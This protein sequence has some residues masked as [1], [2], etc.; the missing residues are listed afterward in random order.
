MGFILTK[1]RPPV[2]LFSEAFS[3]EMVAKIPYQVNLRRTIDEIET[4]FRS[5]HSPQNGRAPKWVRGYGYV[6]MTQKSA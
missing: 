6:E 2:Y 4:F 1:K 5:D 3:E